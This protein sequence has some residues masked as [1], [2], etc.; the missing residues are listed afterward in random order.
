MTAAS[1]RDPAVAMRG[2]SK[3]FGRL[4]AVDEVDF[5]LRRGE[6]HALLG[7]NGAG[8]TTLMNVLSG[9]TRPDSGDI[10][11]EGRPARFRSPQDAIDRGIGMVHQHF[12]LVPR[13]TVAENIILGQA[14]GRRV[15][16]PDL[17]RVGAEI[18]A[19]GERYGLEV[20]AGAFVWQLSVGEQQRAE[21]LRAL[22]R[23]ARV[24]ILDEP[25]A[26]LTAG[27]VDGFLE[28]LRAMARQGASIIIISH[29]LDEIMSAA[30]RVT[31]LRR[32]GRV[33]TLN[34][35][36]TGPAELA[37]L[38]VG[39]D[40]SL[41]EVLTAAGGARPRGAGGPEEPDRE[42]VLEV[43]ELVMSG[44]SGHQ[45]GVA[46]DS[47]AREL[48]GVNLAVRAG[49]IVSIAGVEGNG[50]SQ[51]EE[52]L[53]GLRTP[54]SGAV[55]LDGAGL[56][57]APTRQVLEAGVGY[58]PSDRYRYGLVSELSVAENLVLDR[59][60]RPP[61]GGPLRLRSRAITARGAELIKR[62]S[63]AVRSP[64]EQAAALSG[65]NAQRAVLARAMSADLRLCLAAQ[66]TR[67][68]D[69]G[70]IEFVWQRLRE[71]RRNGV[72]VLLISTDLDEVMALSDRCYVMH[73][74]RLTETP[75]D[76]DRIGLAMG[77]AAA[78]SAPGGRGR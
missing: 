38:M 19:L 13:L 43:E 53:M 26:T 69:V 36:E 31:V 25:T 17:G 27:E 18:E 65:G 10:E 20:P 73:R 28:G 66:P 7:E 74:G 40:V 35:A 8:K 63:I 42:A 48:R 5:D 52:A 54:D 4:V 24:L 72:A 51:L 29:N 57:G 60:D 45:A 23:R 15:R 59:I 33:A 11:V 2:V 32:G 50:Q 44:E 68:L 67:G 1:D 56:T 37:R 21:I 77:G 39:R 62:F 58:I 61:Y 30:D 70:A 75:L 49:E 3:R 14:G 46:A 55:R 47:G 71:Q 6:I 16:L 64:A 76:R 12:K 9:M 41:V 34:R 22:Y 78:E